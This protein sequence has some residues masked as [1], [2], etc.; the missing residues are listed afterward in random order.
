MS[1]DSTPAV[2]ATG[3]KKKR[4]TGV[5]GTMDIKRPLNYQPGRNRRERICTFHEDGNH[6]SRGMQLNVA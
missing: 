4:E 6:S 1:R 5:V 2:V 3:R